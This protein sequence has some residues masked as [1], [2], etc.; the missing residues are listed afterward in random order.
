MFAPT[1][2]SAAS[3]GMVKATAVAKVRAIFAVNF[4]NFMLYYS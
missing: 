1:T 4:F 2:Q 3:A